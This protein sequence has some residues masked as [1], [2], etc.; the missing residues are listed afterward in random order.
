MTYGNTPAV[1]ATRGIKLD[2]ATALAI[3]F[4]LHNA[5][6]CSIL[7]SI[8]TPLEAAL[9]IVG[10]E[11][12][13]VTP[14][15]IISALAFSLTA[16]VCGAFDQKLVGYSH[17]VKAMVAAALITLAGTAATLIPAPTVEAWLAVD[18]FAG[19]TTGIGSALLAIFWGV[20]LSHEKPASIT[21]T[22]AIAIALGYILN[23]LV[24]QAI[25][26]PAHSIVTA[27]IPLA[28]CAILTKLLPPWD[29]E[30]QSRSPFNPLP[31]K[32][33]HLALRLFAPIALIGFALGILKALSVQK[34]LGSG[35]DPETFTMLLL[36]G[37]LSV[38]VFV[39][40][41]TMNKARRWDTFL[42]V[43]VPVIAGGSLVAS[44][45]VQ[46]NPAFSN[47]FL[48]ITYILA[49]SLMWMIYAYVAHMCRLSP[50][51][52][53]GLSRGIITLAILAGV[54]APLLA[55][56][57]LTQIAVSTTLLV[58]AALVLLAA[59]AML[60]PSENDLIKA[61]VPCPAVRIISLELDEGL[62]ILGTAT[63][64]EAAEKSGAAPAAGA[65]DARTSGTTLAAS[66]KPAD[67]A[68]QEEV[69]APVDGEAGA[70]A[71]A[72]AGANESANPIANAEAESQPPAA[73]AAQATS[74]APAAASAPAQARAASA[75]PLGTQAETAGAP[76]AQAVRKTNESP[77]HTP[78]ASSKPA[79]SEA[80]AAMLHTPG[81]DAKRGDGKFS[82]KVKKVAATY[83]LTERETDV[84]FELAKG[85]S[86]AYIQT[87]YYISAG[88]VKTHIRNI[89]RKLDVHKRD[90]LIRLIEHADDYD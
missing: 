59:G 43:G 33:S 90:E 85:N 11:G 35:I 53:F 61:I 72:G 64:R 88:T 39:F 10:I 32:K 69:A 81:A 7:Y 60:L 25:P 70:I 79:V 83:L 16:L 1:P 34:T 78:V 82:H 75:Q 4:G 46:A 58:V 87:K 41:A 12:S 73:V 30:A 86:P 21:V 19:I 89:Y 28:E 24:L 63:P 37:S 22:C 71:G 62:G 84:L 26:H 20:A 57:L 74:N 55:S 31:T 49:E 76:A 2:S 51:F 27:I 50:I 52:L 47:L 18:A 65:M 8:N 36:A 42:R 56:Q 44:L 80:R 23:T 6:V 5:W 13:T 29:T 9:T 68:A 14:L 3:G 54:L 67:A 38:A 66:G 15:Y 45:F 17:N 48:L 40:N 77:V